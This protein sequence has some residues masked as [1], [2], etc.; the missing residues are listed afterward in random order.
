MKK[1]SFNENPILHILLGIFLALETFIYATGAIG[2]EIRVVFVIFSFISAYLCYF[3]FRYAFQIRKQTSVLYEYDETEKNTGRYQKHSNE[4]FFEE[5]L[6][7][8]KD[9]EPD[10]DIGKGLDDGTNEQAKMPFFQNESDGLNETVKEKGDDDAMPD[11]TDINNF[12]RIGRK[13]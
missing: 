5:S 10:F 2:E 7:N 13:G 3:H 8:V 12:F 6:N 1:P 9:K 4:N 11:S